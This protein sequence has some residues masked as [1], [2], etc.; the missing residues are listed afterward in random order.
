MQNK[1]YRNIAFLLGLSLLAVI[2][3]QG[4]WIYYTY[5]QEQEE[6]N[7]LAYRAL[8]TV[9][10]KLSERENLQIIKQR[11]GNDTLILRHS[12]GNQVI[13]HSD[14]HLK[15][16]KSLPQKVHSENSVLS[17]N[18]IS[19]SGGKSAQTVVWSQNESDRM[20]DSINKI[21]YKVDLVE[22]SIDKIE[23]KWDALE[24]K[25]DQIEANS[26]KTSRALAEM[27]KI[28]SLQEALPDPEVLKEK[29]KE[30]QKI[31]KKL[32]TEIRIVENDYGDSL[33]AEKAQNMLLDE[34]SA[35]GISGIAECAVAKHIADKE[36]LLSWTQGFKA[37]KPSYRANLSNNRILQKGNFLLMQFSGLQNLI[38]SRMAKM[39]LLSLLFT[40]LLVA[41]F[42]YAVHLLNRQK[43]LS[44]I[45]NDFINNMTHE[46]KTPIATISL[47]TDSLMQPQVRTDEHKFME[48]TRILKEE[49]QKLNSH[50]ERVLQMAL[51]EK[52]ELKL[53]KSDIDL[54][55]ISEKE[56]H[57]YKLQ[58]LTKEAELSLEAPESVPF[59]G[60]PLHLGN[61]LGNLIDNALKYGG[62]KPKLKVILKASENK[63]VWQVKDEGP[64]IKLEHIQK[65]FDKFYRVQRGVLHEVKGFGLGLSYA[66][67]IVEAHGGNISVQ[68]EDGK[69][70]L[71]N[72]EFPRS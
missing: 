37:D 70:T 65:I 30:L 48:Y 11:L 63:I 18:V 32:E 13:L 12:Q 10:D 52:G 24:Y 40:L 68:S 4:F 23:A 46:L 36:T 2:L 55:I 34:L 21:E 66:R 39:L 57:S 15:A 5:K 17:I 14:N 8:N 60:D 56:L 62:E 59:Y 6:L 20:E 1:D 53:D 50:V 27:D 67:S 22:D 7:R 31:L 33:K 54:K 16:D 51:L 42:L 9:V 71:F 35:L 47:A 45:K 64:G 28:R 58:A 3:L 49:N 25:L 72:M 69:G 38:F 26:A 43:K 44:E 41:V 29:E 61:A 19:R